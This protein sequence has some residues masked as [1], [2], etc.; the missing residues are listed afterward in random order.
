MDEKFETLGRLINDIDS[1]VHGLQIP[2]EAEMHV[3]C[4][5]GILP[6]KVAQFKAVYVDITGENPWS[7]L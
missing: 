5:K 1:L 2:I 6:E 7:D 3:D 4:L